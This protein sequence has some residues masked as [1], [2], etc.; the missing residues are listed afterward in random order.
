MRLIYICSPYRAENETEMDRNIDYAQ[1]L[2]REV[3]MQG[4]APITPHLYMTQC[5]DEKNEEERA[6]GIAAGAEI[7]E[8]CDVV[9]V[10]TRYGISD[11]MR[12][13]IT[14]AQKRGIPLQFGEMPRSKTQTGRRGI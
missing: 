4:G 9:F 13:E 2:T 7:L 8:I 1:Q 5:L 14:T 6:I 3:L 10:G 11:G 12:E